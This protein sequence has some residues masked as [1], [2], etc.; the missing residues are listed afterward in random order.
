MINRMSMFAAAALL[1][2]SIGTFTTTSHALSRKLA[3]KRAELPIGGSGRKWI[4]WS[5]PGWGFV[6]PGGGKGWV[7][8][9]WGWRGFGTYAAP[10][11]VSRAGCRNPV[12]ISHGRARSYPKSTCAPPLRV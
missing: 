2:T 11:Y 4:G 1:A 8:N 10:T 7:G 6:G 3:I 5:G 9:G 12:S